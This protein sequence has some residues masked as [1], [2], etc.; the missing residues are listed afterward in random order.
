MCLQGRR[1]EGAMQLLPRF[2]HIHYTETKLVHSKDLILLFA[3][4]ILHIPPFFEE[5]LLLSKNRI[6][7][8][9]CSITTEK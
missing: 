5:I 4:K 2:W 1:N 9:W 3:T 7:P 8:L 6:E